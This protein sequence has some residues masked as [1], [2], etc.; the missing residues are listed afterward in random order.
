VSSSKGL[1]LRSG[2]TGGVEI[3]GAGLR[4]GYHGSLPPLYPIQVGIYYTRSV[5]P[6]VNVALYRTNNTGSNFHGFSESSIVDRQDGPAFNSYDAR[7]D[8]RGTNDYD[9]YAG[10][11]FLPEFTTTGTVTNLYG[12]YGASAIT[13]TTIGNYYGLYLASPTLDSG[14]SITG[15]NWGIYAQGDTHV[16]G[17]LEVI[18]NSTLADV[19]FSGTLTS[20][21]SVGISTTVDVLTSAGSTN[22]LV[23]S[24]G[25][26]ISNIVDYAP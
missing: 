7:V 20:G 25:I 8:V 1:T 3:D 14:A 2:G 21:T 6:A 16:G 18:S 17:D 9:H 11:Q 12:F 24:N 26:L 10:F 13:N 23:Y 22:R 19:T 4:V 5:D 15:E